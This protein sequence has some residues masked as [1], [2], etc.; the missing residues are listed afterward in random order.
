MDSS[1]W[2]REKQ[3]QRLELSPNAVSYEALELRIHGSLSLDGCQ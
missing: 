2:I 1:W 3:Q